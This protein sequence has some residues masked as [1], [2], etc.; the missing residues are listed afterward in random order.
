MRS[1]CCHGP[2]ISPSSPASITAFTTISASWQKSSWRLIDPSAS[3]GISAAAA[4][5]TAYFAMLSFGL[6]PFHKPVMLRFQILG[7][8]PPSFPQECPSGSQ[9]LTPTLIMTPQLIRQGI[10]CRVSCRAYALGT[11]ACNR[12][13][14]HTPT[15]VVQAGL[16]LPCRALPWASRRPVMTSQE[17][18]RCQQAEQPDSSAPFSVVSSL[19][20]GC[21][22]TDGG[23]A[24]LVPERFAL[25]STHTRT[26]MCC[27]CWMP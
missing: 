24:C 23:L 11:L 6:R 15:A 5:H 20:I 25:A 21:P 9:V 14:A 10:S 16:Q 17:H 26:T 8:R 22:M 4:A 1:Y 2:S 18:G 7:R 27:V 12:T 13:L 19:P 3:F